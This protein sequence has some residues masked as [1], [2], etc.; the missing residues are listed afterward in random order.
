MQLHLKLCYF[1][2]AQF[3]LKRYRYRLGEIVSKYIIWL[4]LRNQVQLP[5]MASTSDTR[6]IKDKIAYRYFNIL[7][8]A[9]TN[10]YNN[11]NLF[12]N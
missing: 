5:L 8:V 7:R 6:D 1:C 10:K 9:K 11:N 3:S 4:C 12:V 2:D